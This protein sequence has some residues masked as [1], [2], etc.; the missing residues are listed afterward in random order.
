MLVAL[1]PAIIV[2]AA[3]AE[4]T[5][6][7]TLAVSAE[8]PAVQVSPQ[9]A[10]RHFFSLPSLEY[11]FQLEA[12]CSEG[13]EPESLVVSIA[14]SRA[15]LSKDRLA[16][17][18]G[19]ELR[20]RVPAQQIPPVVLREFCVID[21]TQEGSEE[22]LSLE[23]PAKAFEHASIIYKAALSAQASLRCS[24]GTEEQTIYAS[25]PLDVELA[26]QASADVDEAP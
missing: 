18:A 21:Q 2:A 11:A 3:A 20:L 17:I 7:H 10:G 13:W 9:P 19:P 22:T 12:R 16:E 15:A 24:K 1:F 8:T 14:D 4:H 23:D 6:N 5:V 26:C 25:K